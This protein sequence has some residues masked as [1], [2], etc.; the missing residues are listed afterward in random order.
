MRSFQGL[1]LCST[2]TLCVASSSAYADGIRIE[3]LRSTPETFGRD[4]WHSPS[5]SGPAFLLS[6]IP[7][8]MTLGGSTWRPADA[9]EAIQSDP[10][11]T[12]ALLLA[13]PLGDHA[14]ARLGALLKAVLVESRERRRAHQTVSQTAAYGFDVR[15]AR[16]S[17][18]AAASWSKTNETAVTAADPPSAADGGAIGA[19]ASAPG[20]GDTTSQGRTS[21]TGTVSRSDGGGQSVTGSTSTL[22]LALVQEQNAVMRTLSQLDRSTLT[23]EEEA[24]VD[25]LRE[26]VSSTE[27]ARDAAVPAAPPSTTGAPGS[28]AASESTIPGSTASPGATTASNAHNNSPTP[29]IVDS[30]QAL[31][32]AASPISPEQTLLAPPFIDAPS[33]SGEL[34]SVGAPMLSDSNAPTAFSQDATLIAN[35]EPASM[36]LLGTG[37]LGVAVRRYRRR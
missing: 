14:R 35:P 13:A 4:N 5:S 27:P 30:S 21:G 6:T 10:F 3:T 22:P 20:A 36:I 29:S 31:P 32:A 15:G 24:L 16:R 23:G 12:R 25:L 33:A 8:A 17:D 26:L 34:A 1:A 7:A 37:L 18:A 9:I 11:S 28:T 2:L 19:S